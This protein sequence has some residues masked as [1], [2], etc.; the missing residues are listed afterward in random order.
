MFQNFSCVHKDLSD[1]LLYEKSIIDEI[2]SE[3]NENTILREQ[4]V[5]KWKQTF[6]T[7]LDKFTEREDEFNFIKHHEKIMNAAKWEINKLKRD[8][9]EFT[10]KTFT[11]YT[12]NLW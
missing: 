5:L 9:L 2:I 7:F 8:I 11:W 6:Q 12:N 10:T 1:L 4:Y 3:H